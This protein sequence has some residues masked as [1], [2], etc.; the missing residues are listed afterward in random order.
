MFLQRSDYILE[1]IQMLIWTQEY[2]LIEKGSLLKSANIQPELNDYIQ[3]VSLY[4]PSSFH[5]KYWLLV[6]GKF[7][8]KWKIGQ[9]VLCCVVNQP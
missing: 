6:V 1:L 8:G 3:F 4:S 9:K 7:E 2:I 5:Y